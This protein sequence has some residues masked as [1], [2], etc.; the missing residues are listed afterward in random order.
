MTNSFFANFSKRFAR[1]LT[2][3]LAASSIAAF[4][5]VP[6]APLTFGGNSTSDSAKW[7]QLMKYKLWAYGNIHMYDDVHITDTV[8]FIGSAK[9]NLNYTNNNHELGGPLLFGGSYNG[10][11]GGDVIMTG[12]VHFLGSFNIGQ[13]PGNDVFNGKYCV[14]SMGAGFGSTR[15]QHSQTCDGVPA[16][17]SSLRLPTLKSNPTYSKTI[18]GL[19][20][21][22]DNIIIDVPPGDGV[23]D[24]HIDGTISFDNRGNVYV[25]MPQNGRPT[26][27]FLNGINLKNN[28]SIYVVYAGPNDTCSKSGV[29]TT[30]VKDTPNEDYHGDLLF[31]MTSNFDIP[32]GRKNL[33]GTYITTGNVDIAQD[34]SFAGQLIAN[35]I[36]IQAHFLADQFRYVPFDPPKINSTALASGL[37]HEGKSNETLNVKLDKAPSV[38]VKIKY[39]FAFESNASATSGK[40][41][42]TG[43]VITAAHSSDLNTSGIPVCTMTGTSP[44][45]EA[46]FADDGK[47][48]T[49]P[50]KLT[51]VDDE[52]AEN[53]EY[54]YL[55]ILDIT[56]GV[57][58]DGGHTGKFKIYIEDN[59]SEPSG[60][61]TII[62]S[63]VSDAGDSIGFE[64]VPFKI[65]SFPAY[66]KAT[67][68]KNVKLTPM[69]D[70]KVQ[71]VSVPTKGSLKKGSKA[72]SKGEVISSADIKSGKLTYV[73]GLNE[74]GDSTTTDPK[75]EYSTF[76]YKIVDDY[77][78]ASKNTFTMTIAMNP[79]NDKPEIT[80]AL[81]SDSK[82]HLTVKE[83][84]AV[85]VKFGTIT[86][87]DSVDSNRDGGNALTYKLENISG[88]PSSVFQVNSKTGAITVK[89]ATLNYEVQKT[90]EMR[91]IVTDN[92][93]PGDRSKKLTDTVVVHVDVENQNDPPVILRGDTTISVREHA[94]KDSIFIEYKATDEDA[95]QHVTF[96][97]ESADGAT[98]LPFTLIA[99]TD[100]DSAYIKVVSINYETQPTVYNLRMIADDGTGGSDTAMLTI[101]I[102]DV[103]ET[104]T[105]AQSSY[106]FSI[107]EK[108]KGGDLVGQVTAADKDTKA[109][110]KTVLTYSLV[111]VNDVTNGSTAVTGLFTVNSSTGEIN[112]DPSISGMLGQSYA[113]HDYEVTVKVTDNGKEQ[114][115]S[116]NK[117]NLSRNVKVTVKIGNVNDPPIFD[118]DKYTFNVNENT[119]LNTRFGSIK[120]TD[121]DEEDAMTLSIIGSSIPFTIATVK[122]GEYKLSVNG[123]LDFETKNSYSF[124]VRVTDGVASDTAD[125]V[126]KINDV[127][128]KP[129]IAD[130]T[131][132]VDEN[133][134]KG[135]TVGTVKVKDVDT[136]TVMRYALEDSTKNI[137]NVFTITPASSCDNGYFCGDIKLKDS[138]LD[139]E[140]TATYYMYVIATDNGENAGFPP[141]MSDTAVVT[142]KI[143]DKNDPPVIGP[144]AAD[145]NVKEHG[146]AGEFLVGFKATD[147][148]KNHSLTFSMVSKN[149]KALPFDIVPV[150]G[151]DSA[152][153]KTSKELD[154]ETMDT[155]YNI[156]VIVNDGTAKDTAN[157]TVHVKDINEA[158]AFDK[159]SY[160]ARINEK[161]SG[162][163]SVWIF[164]AKDKDIKAKPATVLTYSLGKVYDVTDA[165]NKV[166]VTG[167]F[168][169]SSAS[170]KGNVLVATSGMLGQ[171]YA[172]HTFEVVVTVKDNGSKQSFF[173]NKKDLS[174]T[175]K[176]TIVVSNENDP[177]YLENRPFNFDVDENSSSG[178]LVGTIKAEDEDLKD[179]LTFDMLL[180]SGSSVPFEFQKVSD[181]EIKVVV[182]NNA[183]LNYEADSLYTFKVTVTDGIASDTADVTIKINDVNEYP[184]IV[185]ADLYIDENSSTGTSVGKVKVTD[186]DLWTKMNYKLLD[187]TAG[188]TSVFKISSSSTCDKG[189]F[190]GE[191]TLK[192]SVL[193]YEKDSVYYM[194]VVATDNGKDNGFKSLADTA[195]LKVHINDKNDSP[196]FDSSSVT[197]GVKENSPVGTSVGS[198]AKYAKDEDNKYTV[199]DNLAYSLIAVSKNSA[200]FFTID[201]STGEITVAMDSLDYESVAV[202]QVKVRVT[203]N[204][205]AKS[206]DTMLVIINVEDVNEKPT[207]V[208]QKFDVDELEPVGTVLNG[209]PVKDGDLDTAKAF[210]MHKYFAIDGDTAK[211]A[212]DSLTG[213]LTTKEVLAY[214]NTGTNDYSLTVKVVDYSVPSKLLAAEEVML[215][216]VNDVN[217]APVIEPDTFEIKENSPES[218]FVGQIRATDDEDPASKLLFSLVGSSKEFD[219]STDGI[220]TVKK[221]AK[222]DYERTKSYTL[223]IEVEDLKG[224]TTVGKI[225]I[226]ILNVP[227][228]PVIEADTF[229]V[230][231][232]AAAKTLVG[233]AIGMD[234]EDADSLLTFALVGKSDEFDVSKSGRIT[235]KKSGV[236]DYESTTSYVLEI[237][238]TDTDSMSDTARFLIIVD[239]VNEAPEIEPAEFHVA[240][241]SPA[242]TKVGRVVAHDAEEPDSVLVFA[243]AEKSNEFEISSSGRITVKQG[244]N[245]DYETKNRY[246]LKVS[247]TDTKKASSTAIVRIL[248]DDIREIPTIDDTTIVIREDAKPDTTFAKLIIDNPEGDKV[249]VKLITKTKVFKISDDGKITLID[250]LD[251]ESKKKYDLV[252]TVEGE[253]GS[254]DTA[255][256]TIKVQNV[257]EVPEVKITRANDEDSLWLEPDTIY[258]HTRKVNLEWTVD[259]KLQPD[260]LV[261]LPKD[262]TYIVRLCY[263]DPTKDRPGC[264]TVVIVVDNSIPKV[265]ISK[266]AEDTAAISNVTIVEQV[267]ESDTNFYVNHELNEVR[268]HIRDNATET[269]STF[270]TNLK[271]DSLLNIKGSLSDIKKVSKKKNITM[272]D[273]ESAETRRNLINNKTY[274]VSFEKEVNGKKLTVSYNTDKKGNPIKNDDGVVVMKVEFQTVVGGKDVTVSYYVNGSTG[275][276]IENDIGGVYEYAYEFDDDFGGH[277][278]VR[279]AVDDKGEIIKNEEGNYG[280]QV[281]YTYK[282]KF[283]NVST[284]NIF[285]VVDK[286]VPVVKINS[287]ENKSFVHTR[288][289][290]VEWTVDGVVQDTLV[291]QALKNGVNPI[292]RTYRDKAGNEASDTV[293]VVLKDPKSI[294]VHVV[295]PVTIID[296]DS[297]AKYYG[298]NPPK[299][300]QTFAVSMY[301][302]TEDREAKTL[303]GGSF[304]KKKGNGK[305]PYPGVNGGHLGPTLAIEAVAPRCGENPAAGLCTL[306]DLVERDGMIS[307]GVGGGWDRERITVDEYV[308]N[309]CTKEFRKEYKG[310]LKSA[311]LY[312]MSLHVNVWIY[313]NLGSFLNEYRFEQDLNDPKYVSDVGEAKM[314]FELTPDLDGDVR[315]KDGRLLGT[316][317]YIFKTEVKSVAELRCELPDEEIG[318]KR[319]ASDE[320]LKSFGYKRPKQ[321]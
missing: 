37:L 292:V 237:Y 94:P 3:L 64:D 152:Y 41:G 82:L 224:L 252:V 279:Y 108:Y 104:P 1:S 221:G 241:N 208:Q 244:A 204:R 125:V 170:N 296:V 277:V 91:I 24:L 10:N 175:T 253:D 281:S 151:K 48:L 157:L 154:Y 321:K 117:K 145:V 7:E 76:T 85:G 29:W 315:T 189:Y 12:P 105:F 22:G 280:Y 148:D 287:P 42:A 69:T 301:D 18:G 169:I 126:V 300:G 53:R 162:G 11:T 180:P 195:L 201:A 141:D 75:F 214:S 21:N 276:L 209:S 191:I 231:E 73:S 27:I 259:K 46:T 132:N 19:Y 198:I 97:M 262:S 63:I 129:V 124:K 173:D 200:K 79:V 284:K 297:V 243:L 140:K 155:L 80:N 100:S 220:I 137:A 238:V 242:K 255:H 258:T 103:N 266:T 111:G 261:N 257:L 216:T 222:L 263:D 234:Q 312:K 178:T 210:K 236:L 142:I 223:Q 35:S 192:D 227:E 265:T 59:D 40:T 50:I 229:H 309:Y 49:T 113:N 215:I 166:E 86:A 302:P 114:N 158:P 211:F 271:L 87:Q 230:A 313:S 139:F 319:H 68:G 17:D 70:Y 5:A 92:G 320:L 219:V 182:K 278:G 4:A 47:A 112:V 116:V 20:A 146:S 160:T 128:E 248:I 33:Q 89:A 235:V 25:R 44:Y 45:D 254:I 187:S 65:E 233:K 308:N 34:A 256:V 167:L 165:S 267:D 245:L 43:T 60:K 310:D 317:A 61:D 115:F 174:A 161:Y 206:A 55:R 28:N 163:D 118:K 78:E 193:N 240:E 250:T 72:V 38:P 52:L 121:E 199:K 303:V 106:E 9:G 23:Y 184:N 156:Y 228:P 307:L 251:Y 305:E 202:Y 143:N 153:V 194:Y 93:V 39:C 246:D 273:A 14:G 282:N 179:K 168:S 119:P 138:V 159:T 311:N 207:I 83:N 239:D 102:L 185:T 186:E 101:N 290:D 285:I 6:V 96:R 247:V 67:S 30:Q 275:E 131:F 217:K 164:E 232:T 176:L 120:V 90:Y 212:I 304:G 213:E 2:M 77:G 51:A 272:D 318:H 268:I 66:Y 203:D 74:F 270:N 26:R 291:L 13:N 197:V 190:C 226:N 122:K 150:S 274:A 88:N 32:S 196:T 218:T 84:S 316:G 181:R 8:G 264:D 249:K 147:Q 133:S 299:K 81:S 134:P 31:Y 54:F 99:L 127:N 130:Y 289:I 110:P 144:D 183:K 286:V 314:F 294:D 269:D 58:E 295:K 136:W 71:I 57:L 205:D 260:T 149:G 177:P 109:T 135:K 98:S 171:P 36:N 15:G 283:G 293:I 62:T 288:G 123:A 95:G 56:G 225:R 107:D 188:A 16:V 298:D 306:D 172:G